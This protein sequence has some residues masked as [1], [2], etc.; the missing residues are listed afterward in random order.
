MPRH[1]AGLHGAATLPTNHFQLVGRI[2]GDL[3]DHQA[4]GVVHGPAGT[5]KT[6]A[7]EAALE[8]LRDGTAAGTAT[9]IATVNLAF[10]SRPTM[11]LVADEL[12]RA[13][14][15]SKAP[16]SR[17]RFYLTAALIDLLTA[18]PRLVVIDEAQ[19]LT[20]DCIELLRHL[21]DHPDTRFALL[22]VGG[23][24]GWEVLSREPMLRSRVFRRLPF[25]AIKHLH[26][27]GELRGQVGGGHPKGKPRLA[28]AGQRH[29]PRT[30]HQPPGLGH[31]AL[32]SWSSRRV[33]C[34]RRASVGQGTSPPCARVEDLYEVCGQAINGEAQS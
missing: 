8:T 30:L 20:G 6:Y 28:R 16:S 26:P 3:V 25:Q 7:V 33:D 34:P 13:L 10:P 29:Q 31:L 12:L 17:S 22:Y 19:R 15:G 24:G 4:T 2:I 5:G 1:F 11:R 27:V 32:P 14:T 21:H 23:D 18:A 9:T